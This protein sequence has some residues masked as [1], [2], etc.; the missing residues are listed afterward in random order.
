MIGRHLQTDWAV[1]RKGGKGLYVFP[2][3]LGYS[4]VSYVAFVDNMK[5]GSLI[6]MLDN[7]VPRALERNF[8]ANASVS[9]ASCSNRLSLPRLTAR[10]R[11]RLGL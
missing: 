11:S 1:V 3:T 5:V 2:A 9:C 10:L 6:E 8:I 4:R 7:I